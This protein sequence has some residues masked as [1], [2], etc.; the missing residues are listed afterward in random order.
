MRLSR[1]TPG[2]VASPVAEDPIGEHHDVV[3]S[4]SEVGVPT[5]LL[6]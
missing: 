5:N 2:S 1:F 6:L 4:R 3:V